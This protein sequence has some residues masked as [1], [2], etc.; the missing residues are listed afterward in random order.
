MCVGEKRRVII[1]PEL[2]YGE[3][4]VTDEDGNVLIPPNSVV[5]VDI[6]LRFYGINF[7]I[8]I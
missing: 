3:K 4:G 7:W 8:N 1:P 2:G 6:N 5:I